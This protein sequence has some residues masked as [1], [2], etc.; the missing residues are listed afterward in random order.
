MSSVTDLM[1]VPASSSK[2][3]SRPPAAVMAT[4]EV[5]PP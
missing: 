5:C 2:V 1:P 4:H 3:G